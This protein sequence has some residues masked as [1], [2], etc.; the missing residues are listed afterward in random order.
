MKL[1]NCLV[2]G[3]AEPVNSTR[4]NLRA[5]RRCVAALCILVYA[6]PAT[7]DHPL[8]EAHSLEGLLQSGDLI[9][10]ADVKHGVRDRISFFSSEFLFEAMT[11]SGVRHVAIEIPRVLGRQASRIE[12]VEDVEAFA[13]DVI[14]S[15]L[16]HFV[17]PD[18]PEEQSTTTQHR[19]AIAIGRQVLLS[20]QLGINVIFYDFN[21]PLGGFTTFNDPVYRCLAELDDVAWLRYG[22]DGKVT[23]AQRDSAIM[24]ERFSHDDELAAYIEREVTASGGGKLVVI[25]GY[26]HAVMPG[27]IADRIGKR[28]RTSPTVVAVFK[29]D[30]EDKA[31][32]TF[33]WQ[34]S[35][36]LAIDLS[37]PPQFYYTIAGDSLREEETP[38]RYVALDGSRERDIPAICSQLAHFD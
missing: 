26:A 32:H 38:G 36:L 24:R 25:P 4:P 20:R 15:G 21:N 14:R 19:V 9:V 3:R 13:Q 10:L 33:L 34:Q 23:K 2:R 6:F 27:G 18:H 16:W 31:F 5:Y 11:R 22:L 28:L 35:R 17:D 8:R 1:H 29:D 37:R 12:T 30:T 7:A